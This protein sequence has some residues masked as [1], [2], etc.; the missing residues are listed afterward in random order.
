M[1]AFIKVRYIALLPGVNLGG[2]KR[3]VMA[4]LTE[5]FEIMDLKNERLHV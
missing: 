3:V 5:H 4:T 1:E 2:K